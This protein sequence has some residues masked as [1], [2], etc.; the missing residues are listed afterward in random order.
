MRIDRFLAEKPPL[1]Y[2]RIPVCQIAGAFRRGTL[3]AVLRALSARLA[4]GGKETDLILMRG[5]LRMRSVDAEGM[6]VE[7]EL[8]VDAAEGRGR[9]AKAAFEAD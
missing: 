4:C 7:L 1:V 9:V 6:R 2:T 3:K 5:G 8:D